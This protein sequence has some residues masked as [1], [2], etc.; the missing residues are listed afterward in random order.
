M[1][2]NRLYFLLLCTLALVGGAHASTAEIAYTGG[3]Y[4]D[5]AKPGEVWCLITTPPQFKTVSEEF[6]C[7]PASCRFEKIPA[8]YE[9]QSE[10]VCCKKESTRCIDIPAVYKT[11]S[12]EVQKC[13]C[14]TEWQ[15]VDCDNV[16]VSADTKEQKGVCMTLVRVPA[17]FETRCRQVCVTP[18]S[19]RTEVVPAQFKT[20]EK[21]VCTCEKSERRIEIPARYETRTKEVCVAPNRK[22]WRLT[23]CGVATASLGQ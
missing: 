19:T 10:Q 22:V 21:R 3:D 16:N 18:A 8:V 1:K 2:I 7:Q 5:G 17:T 14:R 15:K 4:P 11:E 23:S 6:L 12:Y 20:I 13:A 9:M